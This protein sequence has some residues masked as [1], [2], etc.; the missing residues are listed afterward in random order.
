MN[1]HIWM[2]TNSPSM[3]MESLNAIMS[4]VSAEKECPEEVAVASVICTL[5]LMWTFRIRSPTT[6]GRQF[7][8]FWV[9]PEMMSYDYYLWSTMVKI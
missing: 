1:S 8:R 5:R 3:L 2:D 4:C 7:E 6:K 9:D